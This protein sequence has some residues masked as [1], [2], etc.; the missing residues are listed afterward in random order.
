MT[1]STVPSA[2]CSAPEIEHPVQRMQQRVE[3][4]RA[5]QHRDAEALLQLARERHDLALVVRVEADERLVQQQQL[6]PPEQR[7]GQQQPLPLAARDLRQG[8]AGEGGRADLI[9]RPLDL[10]AVV[11][12]S[13]T[14][15][16]SDARR[17]RCHEVASAE[18]KRGRAA[19][20]RHVADRRIAARGRGPEHPDHAGA[21]RHEPE[22]R[23]HQRR[24]ARAVRAEH[25]DELVAPRRRR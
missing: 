18:A 13:G 2:A 25:A 1:S 15:G 5:E 8:T 6:G 23:A 10:A 19:G 7:L 22:D 21:R 4:V 24:L 12:G 9:E 3:F 11:R 17:S 14:A 16:P 20:L